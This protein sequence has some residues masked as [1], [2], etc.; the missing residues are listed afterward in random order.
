MMACLAVHW[1]DAV[2][3]RALPWRGQGGS[4]HVDEHGSENYAAIYYANM[5]WQ[6]Q[7]LGHTHYLPGTLRHLKKHAGVFLGRR[8][9]GPVRLVRFV[10]C[11]SCAAPLLARDR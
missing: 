4:L 8:H 9:L 6:P 1:R 5:D 2:H 11:G 10:S 3:S 7:W